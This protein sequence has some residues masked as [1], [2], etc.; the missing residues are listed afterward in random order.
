MALTIVTDATHIYGS[1]DGPTSAQ[2]YIGLQPPVYATLSAEVTADLV[3]KLKPNAKKSWARSILLFVVCYTSEH[4]PNKHHF[5]AH[6]LHH[7]LQEMAREAA[8]ACTIDVM[9]IKSLQHGID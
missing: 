1:L 6:N 5:Q 7:V 3:N 8:S 4:P 9:R 2:V